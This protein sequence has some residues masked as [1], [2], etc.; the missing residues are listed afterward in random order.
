MKIKIL[1]LWVTATSVL[2]A[3]NFE[4]N[5]SNQ[6]NEAIRLRL[7]SDSRQAQKTK[8]D[9]DEAEQLGIASQTTVP[10]KEPVRRDPRAV[11]TTVRLD[12]DELPFPPPDIDK[13]KDVFGDK[14]EKDEILKRMEYQIGFISEG[15]SFNNADLRA[16]NESNQATI[17]LTDDRIHMAYSRFFVNFFF[18]LTEDTFFRVDI[19]KNGFWGGDQLSGASTNN[20]SASTPIGADPFAFGE[21]YLQSVLFKTARSDLMVRIGRQ[22]FE[23]GGAANDYMLRDILDA[24]TMQYADSYLGVFHILLFDVYQMAGDA[25][26]N[27]NFVRFFSHD[28]RR[29]QNFDGDV[30]TIRSGLVYESRNILNWSRALSPNDP[31]LMTRLYGFYAR[32]G[33]VSR[34]GSDRTNL[35]AT[36]NFADNDYSA[37]AG[38]RWTFSSPLPLPFKNKLSL[39]AD[40]AVSFG[41]DRRLPTAA[42]ESQ[43]VTNN[44]FAGGGGVDFF[45]H[46]VAREF[47][48]AFNLDGFWASGPEYNRNGIQ[49]SHGFVSFKGN[50]MGG[51]LVNRFWGVHPTAYVANDG[52]ADF[53]HEY[54]KKS[55]AWF[56]HLGTSTTWR[57][58]LRIAADYWLM[59]DTGISDLWDAG[60]TSGVTS[61]VLKAQERL[62]KFMGQEF[63]LSLDYYHNKYW[64][65][66][67]TGGLFIPGEFYETPGI[68]PNSP[69]GNDNFWGVLVGSKLIF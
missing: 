31:V 48:V 19:F 44:G 64:T 24:V 25:T 51:L 9:T 4:R 35:G 59:G 1:A 41:I 18:P 38:N 39:Y 53:P 40:G 47:D 50:H 29:V 7:K 23:V 16:L 49:T 65:L 28:N 21:L 55:G 61:T 63:N 42:G 26:L 68:K 30:N 60:N 33:A 15:G 67:V 57:R 43:D 54:D 22:F 45:I 11:N 56:M 13:R 17:D 20:N 6:E 62:G 12:T 34:G 52:V 69:Y 58:L 2:S 5:A 8:T 10:E 46:E 36:G 14:A 27:I 32:Y 66:Y 3:Q 37:M